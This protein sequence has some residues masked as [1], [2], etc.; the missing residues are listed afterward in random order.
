M[1]K[2]LTALP[3]ISALVLSGCGFA[4][5]GTDTTLQIAPE[6]QSTTITSQDT[7]EAFALKQPLIRHLQMHGV[8]QATSTNRIHL[9]NVRFRR[10]ELVGTLTEVRLVLTADVSYELGSVKH[11]HPIQS[12]H[13][14]QYNEASVAITD[15]QGEAV[16]VWLYDDLAQRIAEQY[17]TLAQRANKP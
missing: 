14:Y 13:S 16:K 10:Y 4:L 8:S 6:Y 2:L 15:T 3:I 11:S 5:R 1:P 12:E 7:P 9:D 17:R